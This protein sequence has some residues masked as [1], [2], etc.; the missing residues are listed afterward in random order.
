MTTFNYENPWYMETIQ[1]E[2]ELQD[3]TDKEIERQEEVKEYLRA[4]KAVQEANDAF[5]ELFSTVHEENASLFLN[6]VVK[7]MVDDE[8]Y[9]N[10]SLKELLDKYF[11][12]EARKEVTDYLYN[13]VEIE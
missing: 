6:E 13:H 4:N 10:I 8:E 11:S 12:R 9:E 2:E 3:A 1:H 5:G 7:A